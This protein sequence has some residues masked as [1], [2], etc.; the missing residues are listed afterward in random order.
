MLRGEREQGE[1]HARYSELRDTF[2]P[3]FPASAIGYVRR[4]GSVRKNDATC[5]ENETNTLG[6]LPP[7]IVDLIF[8]RLS[9]PA[10]IAARATCRA[11][12]RMIMRSVWVLASVLDCVH[13]PPG[14]LD[15]RHE[16]DEVRLRLLQK[17]LD[18]QI[19]VYPG[20]RQPDIWP[21]RFRRRIV[22][23]SN[24]EICKH[25]H[26]EYSTSRSRF[27]SADFT[28]V[29]RFMV[30]LVTNSA[31]TAP[32]S[33]QTHNVVLYQIALSGQPLCVGSL[34]SPE[35]DTRLNIVQGIE[36]QPN[37]SWSLT[38]DI[39]GTARSYSIITR[40]AYAK[41]DVPFILE[42]QKTESTLAVAQET[43]ERS[44]VLK[45]LWQI[46]IYLPYITV[47]I[48]NMHCFHFVTVVYGYKSNIWDPR[49]RLVGA[50][51]RW[52]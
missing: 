14:R 43:N 49:G 40:E 23:F 26:Q 41:S 24:P 30:L 5:D 12:W 28:P 52:R 3:P 48:G 25:V 33:Q 39:D 16:Y 36:T 8:S 10:L 46:L 17:E 35:S 51:E 2:H 1:R 27:V 19:A 7:E 32:I 29:G 11:W 44:P 38:I 4:Y 20:Y 50:L 22:S 34:P 47:S 18:R 37:K 31:G 9:P 15:Q 42:E 6:K 21:L 13:S 45:R